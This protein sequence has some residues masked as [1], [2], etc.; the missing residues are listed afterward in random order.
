MS[1]KKSDITGI[2]DIKKLIDAFYRRAMQ[3][4]S[5]GYFFTHIAEINLVTHLPIM[6]SFWNAVLFGEAGYKN[7]TISKH[8]DL[9][10]K[11]PIEE[12]HFLV[13]KTLFF[14]TIDEFFEGEIANLAKTRAESMIFLMKF[15]IAKSQELGFI[16]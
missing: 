6:Y 1:V 12:K 11:E 10:R 9:N 7:N 15:K 2:D 14:N 13:W 5:I 8:I 3:D 16:K 4:E